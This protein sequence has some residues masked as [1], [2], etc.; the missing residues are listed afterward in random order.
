[1]VALQSNPGATATFPVVAKHERGTRHFVYVQVWC[2]LVTCSLVHG[3]S[4]P[5]LNASVQFAKTVNVTSSF[6][7][8]QAGPWIMHARAP[9]FKS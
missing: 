7:P 4:D 9:R 5:L 2:P 8:H 3:Q 6:H 1:M